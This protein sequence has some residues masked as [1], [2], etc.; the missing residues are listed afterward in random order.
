MHF[1]TLIAASAFILPAFAAPFVC[2]GE[3]GLACPDKPVGGIFRPPTELEPLFPRE[4]FVCGIPGGI[5]CPDHPVG[6]PLRP[7]FS[8]SLPV[9]T[10]S[11]VAEPIPEDDY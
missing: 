6:G 2:G 1:S 10:P 5:P 7:S 3:T 11:P 9:V 8:F 4:P